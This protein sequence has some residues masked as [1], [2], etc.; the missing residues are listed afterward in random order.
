MNAEKP[1]SGT[2][3][4]T[5]RWTVRVV[6]L[7]LVALLVLI[8]VG[9]SWNSPIPWTRL[10]PLDLA[11]FVALG[12]ALFGLLIAW[13]WELTGALLNIAGTTLFTLGIIAKRGLQFKFFWIEGALAG[14]GFVFLLCWWSD[15][16]R[17]KAL[18][19][20]KEDL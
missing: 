8:G 7:A 17:A 3:V 19:K 1:G 13:R 9:E 4:N 12:L 11:M 16:R 15:R 14:F 10:S 2:V 18:R 5:A 6:S 20:G